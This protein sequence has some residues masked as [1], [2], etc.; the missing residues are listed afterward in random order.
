MNGLCA[1]PGG[2]TPIGS[3]CIQGCGD[4]T[5]DNQEECDDGDNVSGDGC[6]ATCE[7]EDGY[8]CT[9]QPSVCTRD[10]DP[11]CGNGLIESGEQCDDG[12][13]SSGDGC[14]S[15]CRVEDGYTCRGEPSVC[16][17]NG[18]SPVCGNGIIESGEQCD[19]GDSSSGD[20]CS[21]ICRVEDGYTCRGVPSVCT[22][23][24]TSN[25]GASLVLADPVNTNSNNIFVILRTTPTFTFDS[26]TEMQNFIQTD[27]PPG[28]AIP[29]VY[30]TQ[31]PEELDIFECLLI[32]PSGVPNFEYDV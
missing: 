15:T 24:D 27:F 28:A 6:S 21:S 7:V 31:R 17:R 2:E 32:Y 3:R 12:D 26:E 10:G 18:G 13:S 11:D 14:S 16:T 30:C 19:D 5:I 29:T 1:C 4:G 8:T 20:G 23:D 25:G 9:G 22:R